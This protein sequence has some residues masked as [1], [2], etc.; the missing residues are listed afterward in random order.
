VKERLA[1][2]GLQ[3]VT[4]TPQQFADFIRAEIDKWGKVIRAAGIKQK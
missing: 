1:N 3:V 2:A 4:N